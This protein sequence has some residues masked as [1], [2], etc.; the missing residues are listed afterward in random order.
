MYISYGVSLILVYDQSPSDVH[1]NDSRYHLNFSGRSAPP[2]MRNIKLHFDLS[3]CAFDVIDVWC[4]LI[5]SVRNRSVLSR[6]IMAVILKIFRV[7][8]DMNIAWMGE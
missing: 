5:S 3:C 4:L 1:L 6:N 8:A 2:V 7:M